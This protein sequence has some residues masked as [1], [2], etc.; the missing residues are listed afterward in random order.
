MI[1]QI[2]KFTVKPEYED[3]FQQ[4]LLEHQLASSQETGNVEM[5][6]YVDNQDSNLFFAYDRWVNQEALDSHL[7]QA[8]T[9][10]LIKLTET[11]LVEPAMVLNLSE[12]T[13]APVA[14]KQADKEDEKFNIFFILDHRRRGRAPVRLI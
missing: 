10:K 1:N 12:T 3:E 11:A 2:V 4:Q 6:I 7:Q 13:P 8:H 14:L 5:R 9:Q